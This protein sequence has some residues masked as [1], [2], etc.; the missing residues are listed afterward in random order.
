MKI[1]SWPEL[2]LVAAEL[3]TASPGDPDLRRAAR[4]FVPRSGSLSSGGT[5]I[6]GSAS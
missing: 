2:E 4:A 5:S 6:A 1:F 3:P